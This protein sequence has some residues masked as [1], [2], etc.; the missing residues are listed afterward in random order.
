MPAAAV[1]GSGNRF[2]CNVGDIV[3]SPVKHL[4]QERELLQ[5]PA[6]RVLRIA[7]GVQRR[8]PVAASSTSSGERRRGRTD[9]AAIIVLDIDAG[10][11]QLPVV[12]ALTAVGSLTRRV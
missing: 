6:V 8:D 3:Q 2:R 1:E 5:Q 11:L 12:F 9:T 4:D 10:L 7:R